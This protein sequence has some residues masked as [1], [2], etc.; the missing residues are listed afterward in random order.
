[1]RT[2]QSLD[3]TGQFLLERWPRRGRANI[4]AGAQLVVE[5]GERAVVVVGDGVGE[6]VER[7]CGTGHHGLEAGIDDAS[8]TFL[9]PGVSHR[10]LWGTPQPI[11]PPGQ[12]GPGSRGHGRLTVSIVDEST[13]ALA[14][15]GAAGVSGQ[16][17]AEAYL[18]A[19]VLER[20]P[21]VAAESLDVISLRMT[22][23]LSLVLPALGLALVRF[24]VLGLRRG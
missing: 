21:G 22:E 15:A 2:I 19:L 7:A 5:D 11:S 18:R 17:D 9:R 16:T 24:E 20:L 4:P 8:V 1:L 14:L 3:P 23:S 6:R 13:V 12:A 10:F